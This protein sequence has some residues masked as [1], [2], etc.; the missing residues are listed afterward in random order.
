M[1][2]RRH[3]RALRWLHGALALSASFTVAGLAPD[4]AESQV[5]PRFETVAG[6]G[7]PKAF[8]RARSELGLD[9][10]HGSTVVG[11]ELTDDRTSLD[12]VQVSLTSKVDRPLALLDLSAYDPAA[13]EDLDRIADGA[14]RQIR[15]IVTAWGGRRLDAET[16]RALVRDAFRTYLNDLQSI[17]PS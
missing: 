15:D 1:V 9:G 14:R 4:A 11:D 5:A 17:P 6:K 7:I 16:A 2:Q 3:P 13:R 10:R 8:A 12:A